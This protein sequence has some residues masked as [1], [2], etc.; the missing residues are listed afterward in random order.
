M[1]RGATAIRPEVELR[2]DEA[3]QG[4]VVAYL[5][6]VFPAYA[7]PPSSGESAQA[8]GIG[9]PA[10]AAAAAPALAPKGGEV[11]TLT[12]K[13][14]YLLPKTL[15][16]VAPDTPVRAFLALAKKELDLPNAL[17]LSRLTLRLRF[18]GA[19]AATTLRAL[20]LSDGK[21]VTLVVVRPPELPLGALPLVVHLSSR[22]SREEFKTV[23]SLNPTSEQLMKPPRHSFI[24]RCDVSSGRVL[25][26]L[27]I[28]GELEVPFSPK[29]GFWWG[30]SYQ[31][32]DQFVGHPMK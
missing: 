10:T 7:I 9:A 29:T 12:V 30:W 3:M 16:G 21:E 15:T 24:V 11:W 32:D 5:Q 13:C 14:E 31:G 6:D 17:P 2:A 27:D 25:R 4:R 20:G 18:Q 8:D 28:A 23:A 19:N 1:G 26:H 22:R